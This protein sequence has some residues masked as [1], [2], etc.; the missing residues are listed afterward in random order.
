M[1]TQ[2]AS[3]QSELSFNEDLSDLME[4]LSDEEAGSCVG[5]VEILTPNLSKIIQSLGVSANIDMPPIGI[6]TEPTGSARIGR[7]V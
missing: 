1:K 2:E 6:D 5:G 7:R 3:H 4:E